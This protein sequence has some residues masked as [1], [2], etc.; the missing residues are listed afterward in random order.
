MVERGN[1]DEPTPS[2]A[3]RHPRFPLESC[4]VAAGAAPGPFYQ[5]PTVLS[6]AWRTASRMMAEVISAASVGW[7]GQGG[8][9]S[10]AVRH[11]RAVQFLKP[12]WEPTVKGGKANGALKVSM[13][14]A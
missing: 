2:E 8:G 5:P 13:I 10:V 7:R 6:R 3:L 4:F 14:F 9:P 12:R 11:P 1:S